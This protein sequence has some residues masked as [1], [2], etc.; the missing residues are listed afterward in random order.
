L[1]AIRLGYILISSHMVKPD[2]FIT[3]I[4]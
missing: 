2:G 3:N 1:L 4:Q